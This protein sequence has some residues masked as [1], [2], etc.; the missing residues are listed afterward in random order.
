MLHYG[1]RVHDLVAERIIV[2]FIIRHLDGFGCF[3]FVFLRYHYELL[4]HIMEWE[5]KIMLSIRSLNK[6]EPKTPW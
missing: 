4:R 5:E 1:Q 6:Y 2:F 3:V